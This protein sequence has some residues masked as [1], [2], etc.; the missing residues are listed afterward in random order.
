MHNKRPR[1]I[2]PYFWIIAGFQRKSQSPIRIYRVIVTG[3]IEIHIPNV[4]SSLRA[5]CE[6]PIL[7]IYQNRM[8]F[9]FDSSR[10]HSTRTKLRIRRPNLM[11]NARSKYSSDCTNQLVVVIFDS[12]SVTTLYYILSIRDEIDIHLN[13]NER[14]RRREK[15]YEKY[16]KKIPILRSW[17]AK[18]CSSHGASG[19]KDSAHA[20]RYE[21]V[22]YPNEIWYHWARHGNRIRNKR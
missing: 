4:L 20:Q 19:A 5:K 15:N 7:K 21:S 8:R 13:F 1:V 14:E 6:R 18:R 22:T 17:A 3:T 11:L 12:Y 10:P 2:G 16:A 9:S